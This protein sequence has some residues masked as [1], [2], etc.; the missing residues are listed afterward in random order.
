MTEE[1]TTPRQPSAANAGRSALGTSASR[2]SGMG[3]I[4]RLSCTVHPATGTVKPDV[5]MVD[6][7]AVPTLPVPESDASEVERAI[8]ARIVRA[9]VIPQW[10]LVEA[11]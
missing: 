5:G 7:S 9:V 2:V 1:A 10:M 11:P 8:R 3:A 6:W 4:V